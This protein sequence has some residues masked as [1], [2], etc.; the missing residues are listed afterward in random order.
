[1][2]MFCPYCEKEHKVEIIEQDEIITVRG[3]NFKAKALYY[4]CPET[5]EEFETSDSRH[6]PYAEAYKQYREKHHLLTAEEIREFRNEF[7][8]TQKEL[9]DLLGFGTVTLSR[10]ENGALQDE[11]HDNLLQLIMHYPENFLKQIERNPD[12]IDEDKKVRL[13]AILEDKRGTRDTTLECVERKLSAIEP[14]IF[15]GFRR[16]DIEKFM[17]VVEFFCSQVKIFPTK[18]NKLLF[19]AD[20]F[21]YKKYSTS[22]TGSSY[23]H[24]TYGP[25]PDDYKMIL[26]LMEEELSALQSEEITEPYT[27][28]VLKAFTVEHVNTLEN[29]EKETLRTIVDSL[30]KLSSTAL[31]KLSHSEKA[32]KET[33][34][35]KLIT[36]EYA[37][38]LKGISTLL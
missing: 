12:A 10:Y 15:N 20:Y 19:Y 17:G 23:A 18:L 38:S 7:V 9:A 1:M 34:N 35:G 36:Y 5:G 8:L 11:V 31:S 21:H 28:E 13:V 30:G 24:A 16:F 2:K 26:A 4:R 37:D 33:V 6:D 32:Y 25:V 14:S 27:G 22:I 3:E 29:D